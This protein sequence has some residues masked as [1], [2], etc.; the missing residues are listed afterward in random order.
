MRKLEKKKKPQE[1]NNEEKPEEAA[2]FKD[3]IILNFL[4]CFQQIF[5]N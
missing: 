4:L 3:V 2:M 1:G 5:C